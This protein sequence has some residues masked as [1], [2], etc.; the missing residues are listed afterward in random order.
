MA[1]VRG[2][3]PCHVDETLYGH[4]ENACG[5]PSIPLIAS[6]GDGGLCGWNGAS[7]DVWTCLRFLVHDWGA[8]EADRYRAAEL[9]G[10]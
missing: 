9:A 1:W 10:A 7:T 3:A 6:D 8:R 4:G 2:R 5:G